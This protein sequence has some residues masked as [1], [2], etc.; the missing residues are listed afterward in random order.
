MGELRLDGKVA[1]VTGAGR[2]LGRSYAM[3]LAA[4]GAGVVVNDPGV[5]LRGEG[6]DEGPALAV[7]QAIRANGGAAIANFDSV[8]SEAGAAAAVA[9][10]LDYFGR[11]D[12][13]INNAGIFMPERDLLQTSSESFMRLWQVHVMGSIN[14]ARAAW[15]HLMA[16][17]SGRII[18]TTSHV[19]Y[20]GCRGLL[21]YSVAKGAI[22]G[23]TRS[24]AL[25]AVG[26]GVTVNAVA[27]G[28]MTR[29]VTELAGLP[30]TFTSAAY[31]ASLVAPMLVWLAHEQC[32]ANGEIFGV[33]SGTMTRIRVAETDGFHHRCP[34]PEL[35]RD[36]FD[37]IMDDA[38][39]ETSGLLF[40]ADAKQR[41]TELVA[42]Y[43]TL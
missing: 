4:R 9:R 10:A 3:L 37:R 11:I 41:G 30:E 23:L 27:P 40:S 29:P 28:A 43:D 7:A 20:L 15:S 31:D 36:N 13:V 5:S 25:E 16:Q 19:G 21:E 39:F 32:D 17:S 18:N 33:M 12:I 2:G 6:G 22:H 35:V 42:L 34:T 26:T 1:L 14:I 24:L 38:A 8:A